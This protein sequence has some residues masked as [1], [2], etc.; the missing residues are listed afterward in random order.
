[1]NVSIIT[2]YLVCSIKTLSLLFSRLFTS[3]HN[4]WLVAF[5]E[6]FSV[7][8]DMDNL[9]LLNNKTEQCIVKVSLSRMRKSLRGSSFLSGEVAWLN[10]CSARFEFGT[11]FATSAPDHSICVLEW[12]K[13]GSEKRA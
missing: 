11:V 8:L 10:D 13:T 2:C 6:I 3:F 1:M 4:L 12:R 7:L 5:G 9:Y